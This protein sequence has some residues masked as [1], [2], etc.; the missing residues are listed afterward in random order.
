MNSTQLGHANCLAASATLL[1]LSLSVRH[2]ALLHSVRSKTIRGRRHEAHEFND[3]NWSAFNQSTAWEW[4]D[5]KISF[6]CNHK[7]LCAARGVLGQEPLSLDA[8]RSI[9]TC[10]LCGLRGHCLRVEVTCNSRPI[11][12]LLIL[13]NEIGRLD[14]RYAHGLFGPVLLRRA[15]MNIAN[16]YCERIEFRDMDEHDRNVCSVL[17]KIWFQ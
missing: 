9:C 1:R 15:V 4:R 8:C 7:H 5:W 10:R 13:P 11:Y 17:R 12:R 16:V 14:A 2:I 3:F 6:R